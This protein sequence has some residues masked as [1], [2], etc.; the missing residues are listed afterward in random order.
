[1]PKRNAW[2][3]GAETNLVFDRDM[4]KNLGKAES[5]QYFFNLSY[6]I[7][8]WFSFD[9]KLGVGDMEYN[10]SETGKLD[11]GLGFS[12]A[13]GLRFRVY[14]DAVKRQRAILGFQHISAHPPQKEVNGTKYASIWDEWQISFLV[15]KGVD[16]LE[17]Y[18]GVKASQL[19]IIKKDNVEN[20]WHWHGAKDHFGLIAGTNFD[21][22]KDVYLNVEGRFIDETAFSAA[23]TYKL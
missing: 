9:G 8:D 6:G 11:L 15:S 23:L 14:N 13:Y 16:K 19:F 7:Y 2:Y 4:E 12:G 21:I 5:N 17:P 3:M 22:T 10:P 20:K 18:A 1:M